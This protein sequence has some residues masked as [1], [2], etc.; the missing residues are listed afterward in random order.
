MLRY[1]A[2]AYRL[3]YETVE[4]AGNAVGAPEWL[5]KSTAARKRISKRVKSVSPID[6]DVEDVLRGLVAK[7][8]EAHVRPVI[9]VLSGRLPVAKPTLSRCASASL[10]TERAN[11]TSCRT[12]RCSRTL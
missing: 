12:A 9:L 2:D 6:G 11:L 8:K 7:V 4:P 10:P 5:A 3:T 1:D